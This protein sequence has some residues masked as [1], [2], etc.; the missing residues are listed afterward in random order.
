MKTIT[1]LKARAFDII[2]QLQALQ[3]E[4]NDITLKINEKSKLKENKNER[5]IQNNHS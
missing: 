4:L 5:P 2:I 3:V 1:E